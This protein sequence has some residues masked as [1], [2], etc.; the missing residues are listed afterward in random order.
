MAAD[1]A[2]GGDRWRRVPVELV[3]CGGGRHNPIDDADWRKTFLGRRLGCTDRH[4][5]RYELLLLLL[6]SVDL[7]LGNG[8][9]RVYLILLA[10]R[11]EVVPVIPSYPG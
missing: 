5:C 8:F 2:S 9:G 1:Q 6:Y 11:G 4:W 7:D 3:A 10:H